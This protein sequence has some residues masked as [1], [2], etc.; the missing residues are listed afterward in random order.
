[1]NQVELAVRFG[2]TLLIFDVDGLEPMLYPLA[3]KDLQNAGPRKIVALGDKQLDFN[4]NFRMLLVTRNPSP[5][6]PPDAAALICEV[7]FT[8]TRSG[9]EGQLLG[10][11]IQH[12]QPELESKKSEMLKQ[13]A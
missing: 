8:V 10:I 9:L 4:E 3:R 12:E 7:N 13:G 5:D 11:T 2:K 6:L 1:M